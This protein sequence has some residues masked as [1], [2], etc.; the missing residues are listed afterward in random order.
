M[1]AVSDNKKWQSWRDKGSGRHQQWH[2]EACTHKYTCIHKHKHKHKH[3]HYQC[4]TYANATLEPVEMQCFAQGHIRNI[5]VWLMPTYINCSISIISLRP[6]KHFLLF[7]T[8][9]YTV[10]YLPVHTFVM[11]TMLCSACLHNTLICYTLASP[12]PISIKA[13]SAKDSKHV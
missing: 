6:M 3:N 4:Y 12:S 2:M 10:C 8:H 11:L 7:H 1:A 9:F 5:N 13:K